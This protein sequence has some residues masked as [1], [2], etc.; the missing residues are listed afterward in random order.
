MR[1]EPGDVNELTRRMQKVWII[2]RA[3]QPSGELGTGRI[4]KDPLG[5]SAAELI[6][7][8]GMHGH[9]VGGA[10]LSDASA[11]FIEVA[12][13][14]RSHDVREL[15]DLMRTRV[16]TMLGVSLETELEVW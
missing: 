7:Q 2:K 9:Q 12:P 10:R 3:A 16:S 14:T 1:L 8:V 13:G 11:N 4:F 15:I 5:L 6:E